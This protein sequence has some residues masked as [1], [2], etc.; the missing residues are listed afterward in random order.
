VCDRTIQI[1]VRSGT[2]NVARFLWNT[3]RNYSNHSHSQHKNCKIDQSSNRHMKNNIN[4]RQTT[5]KC[6]HFQSCDKDSISGYT[7]RSAISENPVMQANFTA[8]SSTELQLL[9]TEV[10]H[11]KNREFCTFLL[12]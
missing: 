8:L 6:M 11:C 3:L 4:L 2:I 1:V 10:L 12:L 5:C 9:P 7:I